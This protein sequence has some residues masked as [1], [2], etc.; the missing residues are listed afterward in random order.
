MRRAPDHDVGAYRR[1]L[2]ARIGE[3]APY[4]YPFERILIWGR[5]A[6]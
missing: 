6:R 1:K 3:R 5:P 2:L 4:L